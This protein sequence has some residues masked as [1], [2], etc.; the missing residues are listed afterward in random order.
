MELGIS[1][2]IMSVVSA[3][4]LLQGIPSASY[5]T[6]TA[7]LGVSM[8]NVV[9]L[10]ALPCVLWIS[11]ETLTMFWILCFEELVFVSACTELAWLVQI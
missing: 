2:M 6:L 9:F 7:V 3:S 1:V 10:S 4:E 8:L 5:N 11:S